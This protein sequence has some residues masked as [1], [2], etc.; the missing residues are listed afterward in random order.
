MAT[1]TVAECLRCDFEQPEDA[2]WDIVEDPTLGELTACPECG[3]TNVRSGREI[4]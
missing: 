3:S 4:T 2:E 1:D